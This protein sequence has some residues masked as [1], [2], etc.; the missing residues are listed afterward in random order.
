VAETQLWRDD[1]D[2]VVDTNIISHGAGLNERALI[3]LKRLV[4]ERHVRI[5]FPTVVVLEVARHLSEAHKKLRQN[6]KPELVSRRILGVSVVGLEDFMRLLPLEQWE[7]LCRKA[8]MQFATVSDMPK[9]PHEEL[10]RRDIAREAPFKDSGAGYR[11]ALIWETVR[12]IALTGRKTILL[13]ANHRDFGLA[14]PHSSLSSGLS[15]GSDVAVL[16]S[17]SALESWLDGQGPSS[18]PV[19]ARYVLT[20]VPFA[21]IAASLDDWHLGDVV[22]ARFGRRLQLDAQVDYVND[23]LELLDAAEYENFDE[24]T[25]AFEATILGN[26]QISASVSRDLLGQ[27]DDDVS[28]QVGEDEDEAAVSCVRPIRLVATIQ[29]RLDTNEIVDIDYQSA[30]AHA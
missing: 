7:T 27:L 25:G 28:I 22:G 2:V 13:T 14:S 19:G 11:D 24:N 30:S 9:V 18:V 5:F 4:D 16:Q 3:S 10:V 12:D 21:S 1:V 15:V 29:Y 20:P 23:W 8:L 26:A 6:T 17:V